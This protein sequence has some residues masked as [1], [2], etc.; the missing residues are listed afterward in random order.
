MVGGVDP[1]SA[2]RFP[3]S[4]RAT[5]HNF[6]AAYFS[7]LTSTLVSICMMSAVCTAC[8]CTVEA[9]LVCRPPSTTRSPSTTAHDASAGY[10]SRFWKSRQDVS[11]RYDDASWW[12]H[13]DA[14]ILWHVCRPAVWR[15][16]SSR[17]DFSV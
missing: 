4:P 1:F 17:L 16:A 13:W 11:I 14:V 2:A 15:P 5:L 12:K 7:V 8:T 6:A 9:G 3:M 10:V